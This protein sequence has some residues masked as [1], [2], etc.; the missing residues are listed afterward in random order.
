MCKSIP[1]FFVIESIMALKQLK[2]KDLK[3]LKEKWHKEQDQKC[4]LFGKEFPLDDMVVDHFHALKSEG[5]DESGKGLCRGVLHFQANSIEGKITNAFKRYGGDKYI[6]IVTF[7]RNLADY[8]ENNKI[9]SDEKYIHP[10]EKPKTPKLMKSSYNSLVKAVN[11]K[12]KVPPFTGKFTKKLELLY[13]KYDLEPKFH[14][15]NNGLKDRMPDSG[16]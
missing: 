16:D 8:L 3:S 15:V 13:A 12:Q 7:L 14:K 10:T 2:Q 6:D 9:H 5:P 1:F 11:G 4:P